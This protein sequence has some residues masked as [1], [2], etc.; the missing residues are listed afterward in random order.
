MMSMCMY[1]LYDAL[2]L[3]DQGCPLFKRGVSSDTEYSVDN[4]REQNRENNEFNAQQAELSRQ[5]NASEAEKNRVFQANMQSQSQQW[6]ED[7][8][9][10]QNE[11]NSPQAQLE[12][13]AVAGINPNA[14]FGSMAS[15]AAQSV[16]SPVVPGGS[17]ASSGAASAGSG[18]GIV[19]GVN[20]WQK[21]LNAL[22]TVMK[23]GSTMT[24]LLFNSSMKRA[25]TKLIN[26]E[27]RGKA[28]EN[29]RQESY[30]EKL[31]T[32][33]VWNPETKELKLVDELG[34]DDTGFEPLIRSKNYNKG[35]FQ[36]EKDFKEWLVRQDEN[37]VRRLQLSF[38]KQVAEIMPDVK[39]EVNGKLVSAAD[40]IA[41]L[42]PNEFR[43]QFLESLKTIQDTATSKSQEDLN[44]ENK[45]AVS[46]QNQGVSQTGKAIESFGKKGVFQGSVDVIKALISDFGK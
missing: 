17:A 45:T 44:K 43:K 34:P 1:K 42:K 36:A 6:N 22:D 13:A 5:F 8:W 19:G 32:G 23:D 40:A 25:Q 38:E 46:N 41:G 24:D 28:I 26:E 21:V 12:R 11:Y 33:F 10:K 29:N 37:D 18:A 35:S 27:A 3:I 15:G 4:N 30:D 2:G 9:N 14:I 16:G 20:T 39:V 7:M 31:R